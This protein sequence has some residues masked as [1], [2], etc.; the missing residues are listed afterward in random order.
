MISQLVN[1]P[2]YSVIVKA[3]FCILLA[4]LLSG[5]IDQPGL[6]QALNDVTPSI[7]RIGNPF[8]ARFPTPDLYY[9]RNVWDMEVYD[10]RLYLGHGNSNND[11]PAPNAGPVE[12]WSYNGQTFTTEY[13]VND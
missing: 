4:V 3:L 9:A 11:G 2:R 10:D 7:E 8:S 1:V 12:I 13:T 5:L 6:S